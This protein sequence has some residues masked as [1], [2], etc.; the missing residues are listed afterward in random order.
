MP[1]P[2][3]EQTKLQDE[4]DALRLLAVAYLK[5]CSGKRQ[6]ARETSCGTKTT[7]KLNQVEC[8]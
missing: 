5:A 8:K 1:Q 4:R 7:G 2:T 6:K 3:T